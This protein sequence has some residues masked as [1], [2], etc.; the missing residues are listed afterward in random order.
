MIETERLILRPHE[1]GD[2]ATMFAMLNDP[3]VTHF[4]AHGVPMPR[5]DVWTKLLRNIG[6]WSAF[7]HGQFAVIERQ[8][9]IHVGDTGLA[10]FHRGLGEDFDP[11]P[12]AAWVF[13]R[14]AH[15]KGYATEAAVAAHAW[16]DAK[17]GRK[18]LVCIIAPENHGS[19]AVAR[20]LGYTA[21]GE[22]RFRNDPVVKL[23]RNR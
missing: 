4:I 15:G 16:F 20:K 10:D 13:A 19:L 3:Q 12:E 22:T 1:P 6:H 17:Y 5:A 18:R 23:E 2:F 21:Y 8:S 14:A 7:G 11:Y 9:G